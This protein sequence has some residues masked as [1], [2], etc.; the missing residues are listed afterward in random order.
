MGNAH[1]TD[2]TSYQKS[3][4]SLNSKFDFTQHSHLYP[5]IPILS[6]PSKANLTRI[7]IWLITTVS[8]M[9]CWTLIEGELKYRYDPLIGGA[10]LT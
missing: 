6:I 1:P 10:I 8:I 4:I 5:I 9:E 3:N 2:I 7:K